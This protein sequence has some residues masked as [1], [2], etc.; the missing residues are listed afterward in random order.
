ME[1]IRL[2]DLAVEVSNKREENVGERIFIEKFIVALGFGLV[3]GY[4]F[5]SIGIKKYPE[6]ATSSTLLM[7]YLPFF[8]TDN[9]GRISGSLGIYTGATI[10]S[11]LSKIL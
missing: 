8:K 1:D 11:Y 4:I 2:E 5:G 6:I 7:S 9:S 3:C 10:G